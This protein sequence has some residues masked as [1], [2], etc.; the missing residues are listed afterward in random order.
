MDGN[1]ARGNP[2]LK[3]VLDEA[4]AKGIK[5]GQ[6]LTAAHDRTPAQ[7]GNA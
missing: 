1:K 5:P 3:V 2:F 7:Y 4:G 6:E